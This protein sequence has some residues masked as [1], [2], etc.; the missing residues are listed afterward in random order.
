MLTNYK[1]CGIANGLEY[2][3]SNDVVHGNLG[4]VCGGSPVGIAIG[5]TCVQPNILVDDFGRVRI[6]DFGLA[7]MSQYPDSQQAFLDDQTVQWTAPEILDD[8]GTCSK[9][10]DVFSFAM[11][12]VEVRCR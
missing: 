10:A 4:P 9:G 11:V 3:H 5:L 1:I 7:M 8:S 12:T 6:T 2:L